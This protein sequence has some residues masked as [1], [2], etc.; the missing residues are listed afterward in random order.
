MHNLNEI[1]R[2]KQRVQIDVMIRDMSSDDQ[3]NIQKDIEDLKK[4][5]KLEELSTE[6]LALLVFMYIKNKNENTL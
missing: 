3:K 6:T 5:S 2:M 4:M 1:D